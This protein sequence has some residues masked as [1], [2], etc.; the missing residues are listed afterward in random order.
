MRSGAAV[1]ERT[2]ASP[3]FSAAAMGKTDKKRPNSPAGAGADQEGE[4]VDG[5]FDL[6]LRRGLHQLYDTVAKEP[7]PE[8]L[9]RMIEEDRTSKKEE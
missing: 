5:A 3:S 6:W 2:A 9:L 4:A 8:A 7:I 1:L